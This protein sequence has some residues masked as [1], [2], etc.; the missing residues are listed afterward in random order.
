MS[1]TMMCRLLPILIL[2]LFTV[3]GTAN[4]QVSAPAPYASE[5][6]DQCI[7]EMAKDAKIRVACMTQ[8]SNEYH[9]Q[10]AKTATANNTFVVIAYAAIWSIVA[11]FVLVM[12]LRQ[13]K[14]AL[15]IARLQAELKKAAA[16]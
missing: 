2:G 3:S 11:I 1:K 5:I 16:E 4:A 13:R 9:E 7:S 12:W 8:Y 10:D 15:E 14:L 6:R